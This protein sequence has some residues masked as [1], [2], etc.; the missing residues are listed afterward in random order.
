MP[1]GRG[2]WLRY[3]G[4]GIPC[5]PASNVDVCE[6]DDVCIDIPARQ[7]FDSAVTHWRPSPED[8]KRAARTTLAK[9][10]KA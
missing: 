5:D 6:L 4:S 2:K 8:K 1:D 7:A 3:S 9:G 10:S